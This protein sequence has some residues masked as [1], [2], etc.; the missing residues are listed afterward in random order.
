VSPPRTLLVLGG[1]RAGKS[2]YAVARAAA[3]GGRVAFVATAEAGDPE[4]TARIA[5]HR[6]DRPAGWASIEAPLGLAEALAALD[7]RADVVLVD[8][9]TLWVA[10]LL[11]SQ[12]APADE[13]L[14]VATRHLAEAV[15]RRAFHLIVVSNE[16]GLGVHP[17]T[18]LGRRFRDA[19]GL[20]NQAAAR[21]ADEA[22]LLVAGCPLWLKGA[23]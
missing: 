13:D 14:A 6:A 10:N 4:M 1:V 17:E 2:A 7:G 5:R 8:C 18:A 23:P 11:G 21:V 19:L 9:L 20:V 3:L 16:V 15:A 12:P 22:V